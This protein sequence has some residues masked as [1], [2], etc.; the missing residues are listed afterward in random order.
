LSGQS[1]EFLPDSFEFTG[2]GLEHVVVVLTDR[3]LDADVVG[4]SLRR[5]FTQAKGDLTKLDG[6]DL[7]GE[8]FHRTFLKP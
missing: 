8:Q 2:A 5:Q 6:L 1:P 7:P 4:S 3:A